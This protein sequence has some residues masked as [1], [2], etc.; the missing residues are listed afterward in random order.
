MRDFFLAYINIQ[1]L[2]ISYFSCRVERKEL[3]L[4]KIFSNV[5]L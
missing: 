2:I 4:L 5:Q 3:L 1:M